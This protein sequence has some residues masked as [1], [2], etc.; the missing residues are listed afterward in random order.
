[1]SDEAA[2]LLS[3][4]QDAEFL[5]F[6]FHQSAAPTDNLST[7]NE[8]EPEVTLVSSS[9][10]LDE[11]P[12]PRPLKHSRTARRISTVPKAPQTQCAAAV[13]NI[14]WNYVSGG[15]RQAVA[16]SSSTGS[17]HSAKAPVPRNSTLSGGASV[18]SST[19]W[20]VSKYSAR[21]GT[22]IEDPNPQTHGLDVSIRSIA[23]SSRGHPPAQASSS[24][25]QRALVP[26]R[27]FQAS[28]DDEESR[29]TV[30]APSDGSGDVPNDD[31]YIS[32]AMGGCQKSQPNGQVSSLSP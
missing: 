26:K 8:A 3:D 9:P 29:R 18:S 13:P 10:N 4:G 12:A 20:D 7:A 30:Y 17:R 32:D 14:V 2:R 5:A 25:P 22:S 27:P 21:S 23:S 31:D 6:S 15:S 28:L 1:M 16:P 11:P 24:R 19:S